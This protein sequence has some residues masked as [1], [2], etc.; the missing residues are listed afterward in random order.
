MAISALIR[1]RLDLLGN[2]VTPDDIERS[3][4][5]DGVKGIPGN[6]VNGILQ[7]YIQSRGFLTTNQIARGIKYTTTDDFDVYVLPRS[8]AVFIIMFN[9]YRYVRLLDPSVVIE[10]N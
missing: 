9:A 10:G 1:A 5:T 7:R 3:L 4:F 6:D 2:R 8:I